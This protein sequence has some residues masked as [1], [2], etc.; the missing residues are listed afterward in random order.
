MHHAE[1]Q[2]RLGDAPCVMDLANPVDDVRFGREVV[3]EELD[4][5]IGAE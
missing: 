1:C 3:E 2:A 4:C 5:Y